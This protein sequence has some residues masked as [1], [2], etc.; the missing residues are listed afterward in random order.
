MTNYI[1]KKTWKEFNHNTFQHWSHIDYEKPTDY[2]I[3][4]NTMSEIL[5]DICKYWIEDS[6]HFEKTWRCSKD[7]LKLAKQLRE[8]ILDDWFPVDWI[9]SREEIF[10]KTHYPKI[11][12]K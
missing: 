1:H 9:I 5:S 6:D 4:D 12:Q 10:F 8:S 11:L 7:T 2:S 3:K